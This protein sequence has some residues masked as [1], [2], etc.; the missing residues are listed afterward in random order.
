MLLT[1]CWVFVVFLNVQ[2]YFPNF[3]NWMRAYSFFSCFFFVFLFCLLSVR[4]SRL[5][6]FVAAAKCCQARHDPVLASRVMRNISGGYETCTLHVAPDSSGYF[7][8]GVC[9]F[10]VWRHCSLINVC[11]SLPLSWPKKKKKGK[12]RGKTQ[13]DSCWT[14]LN[15][16]KLESLENK[17]FKFEFSRSLCV[18]LSLSLSL[19]RSRSLYAILS[20]SLSLSRYF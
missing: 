2:H 1:E 14:G 20:L 10:S 15:E 19:A 6:L 5:V 4:F 13:N 12:K 16:P 17:M 7:C 18:C 3:R 11:I 9:R 8:F